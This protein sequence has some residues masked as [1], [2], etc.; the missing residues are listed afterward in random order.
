MATGKGLNMRGIVGANPYVAITAVGETLT[1]LGVA[2]RSSR[3]PIPVSVSGQKDRPCR[4]PASSSQLTN[5]R[6]PRQRRR[7]CPKGCPSI[8]SGPSTDITSIRC[9]VTRYR[10]ACRK[11]DNIAMTAIGQ[12]SQRG[13]A[14]ASKEMG[15]RTASKTSH[16]MISRDGRHSRWQIADALD[17]RCNIDIGD[18]LVAHE[19]SPQLVVFRIQQA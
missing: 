18:G 2:S 19:P 4:R 3:R 9:G 1:S 5:A 7:Q 8:S 12:A 10:R 11:A 14:D 17:K 16:A 6:A 13:S 15:D